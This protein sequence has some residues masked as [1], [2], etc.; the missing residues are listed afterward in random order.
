M[1]PFE[2]AYPIDTARL[3]LR[4]HRADDLD[5]LVAFH[6][7]PAVVR[8]IPWPVRDREATRAALEAKLGQGRLTEPGQW[9]V[10]AVE[11]RAS[12]TVIGEV[13][14]KW[15]SAE[16]RQGELGFAFARAHHA[17]TPRR[18]RPPCCDSGSTSSG[19]TGSPRW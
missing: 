14:L 9:L 15:A 4:P 3:R 10:L 2:P 13:L 16:S 11:E 12:G 17:G 19:C 7:D 6:G 8:H 1:S 5:D 18:Q